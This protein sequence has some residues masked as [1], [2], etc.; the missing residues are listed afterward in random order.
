MKKKDT[1]TQLKK[2]KNLESVPISR[3]FLML[4]N[5]RH[6]PF[7][8]EAKVIAHLCD[9]E[10]ILALA[11]D[12]AKIGLN[13]LERFAL[14]TKGRTNKVSTLTN[15]YVAEGNRRLCALKLLN[16]P[17]LAP[18]KQ[19]KVFEK[20]AEDWSPITTISATV[21][22]ELESVH[23]WMG[24]IHGG[25][26]G[27][28]GRK[29]WDAEQKQRFDGGAKNKVAQALLDYAQRER[30]ISTQERDGKLTTV[31]RFLS[32]E[33]FREKLG[34]D[35]TNSDDI[36]RIKPKAEFDLLVRKF[37]RDVVDKKEAHSR[38]NKQEIVLYGRSL[39]MLRGVTAT[40]IEAE[41]LAAGSEQKTKTGRRTKPKRPEKARHIEYEREVASA[42]EALRNH[43]L[44]S[45]YHSVC[46][47]DLDPHVPLVAIGVWAFFETLTAAAG[48]ADTV[49]FK[50]FL[51]NEKLRNYGIPELRPVQQALERI[52]G[53]GN[54]TKHHK[55]AAT[56][57]GDQLNNDMV[58][59]KMV[60][61]K[62]IEDAGNKST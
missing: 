44:E 3:I 30:M 50:A 49:D 14:I 13:P 31:Q 16:D 52:L 45:L 5:P 41:P 42:L 23:L 33:N 32:N 39:G 19:R 24:R 8:N 4:D 11:R 61:I 34:L 17:E 43:K 37:I 25:V 38:M 55:T 1:M 28:I 58:T 21:F 59:L 12:I 6:E 9:K 29:E 35:Q 2:P 18:A 20:A 7:E 57:D 36:A 47:V 62:C 15:Y 51:S 27:G 53:Y 40:I 46:T 54:T 48:R 26:Q 22:D 60:I 56:Y 10:N